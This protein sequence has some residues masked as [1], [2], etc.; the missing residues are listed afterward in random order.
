MTACPFRKEIKKMKL[1]I[2]VVS[3]FVLTANT[4]AQW[5]QLQN[6]MITRSVNALAS[7]GGVILAGP[8]APLHGVYR[9]TNS[10][11]NW[12]Q[13]TPLPGGYVLSFFVKGIDIFAG[14]SNLA[15]GVYKSTN[16]GASWNG[17]G[18]STGVKALAGNAN[19][20]FAGTVYN[21]WKSSNNGANWIQTSLV[22]TIL[23]LAVRYDDIIAGTLQDG[24]YT[25]SD[26]GV[27]WNQ[28]LQS[29]PVYSLLNSGQD[30]YAGTNTGVWKS[31]NYGSNWFQTSLGGSQTI[32][33]FASYGNSIFAG[34]TGNGVYVS[35]DGGVNWIHKNEGLGNITVLSFCISGNVIFAG[36]GSN[37]VWI[38]LLGQLTGIEPVSNEI[39][40]GFSLSQNYPNPF[41][42]STTIRFSIPAR[43]NV[44][45]IVFN[46]AG[47][48][49]ARPV[50]EELNAG[51]YEYKFD[52]GKLS[53]GVYFYRL[54]TDDFTQTR[55]MVLV[56]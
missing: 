46:S 36:T 10:G 12:T 28:T 39:P 11:A 3:V 43:S 42:P 33:S 6:A 53:S 23:S 26:N 24:I 56:R 7:S 54:V 32:N 21:L 22:Q 5:V 4:F 25:S 17:I 48:E 51:S 38:R 40:E 29:L 30:F 8:Y 47:Q 31:T 1:L 35:N 27:S 55:K 41:N 50:N 52:A 34:A 14:V 44:E 18:L 20:I 9:S 49:V 13:I 16:N 15:A 37:G 45:L 2:I 19:T